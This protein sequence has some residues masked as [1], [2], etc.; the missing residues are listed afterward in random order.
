MPGT[1]LGSA[2]TNVHNTPKTYLSSWSW[3]ST[4]G[5]NYT[6]HNITE[7]NESDPEKNNAYVRYDRN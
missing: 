4:A 6:N 7:R 3:Y 2:D 5:D 1:I